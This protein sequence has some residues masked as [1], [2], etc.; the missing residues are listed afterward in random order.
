EAA[1]EVELPVFLVLLFLLV[2]EDSS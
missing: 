2:G 1:L